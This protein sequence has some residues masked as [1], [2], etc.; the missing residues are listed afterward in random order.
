MPV[1]CCLCF[2]L[3]YC[4]YGSIRHCLCHA[5]TMQLMVIALLLHNIV[6]ISVQ[7]SATL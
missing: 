5:Y 1:A 3:M 2:E 4:S 7:G 6:L